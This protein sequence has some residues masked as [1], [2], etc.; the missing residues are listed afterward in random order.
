MMLGVSGDT[1]NYPIPGVILGK[2]KEVLE[3][4]LSVCVRFRF[5]FLP[6]V[7]DS[8]ITT[9]T[10]IIKPFLIGIRFLNNQKHVF[11]CFL[12]GG[13]EEAKIRALM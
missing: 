1:V 7:V 6:L 8:M 2:R 4:A 9:T 11:F 10:T 12:G 13:G 5:M 3:Y